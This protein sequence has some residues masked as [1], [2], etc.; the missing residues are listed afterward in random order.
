[1]NTVNS[2]GD[3][4]LF[5]ARNKCHQVFLKPFLKADKLKEQIDEEILKVRK[6]L[7]S[8]ESEVVALQTVVKMR[9]SINNMLAY[10]KVYFLLMNKIIYDLETPTCQYDYI[11]LQAT[12]NAVEFYE[13]FGF[14]RVGAVARYE[15]VV[16]ND[17]EGEVIM[18]DT[19]SEC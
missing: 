1:M 3:G 2:L 14:V 9:M 7:Q 13:R 12:E 19:S 10:F 18:H 8:E 4:S 6:L 5:L 15:E 11:V 17:N 16:P